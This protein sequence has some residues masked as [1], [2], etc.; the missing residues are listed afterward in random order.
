LSSGDRQI[1]FLAIVKHDFVNRQTR[2]WGSPNT[3]L[4]IANL[5]FGDRQT[6]FRRLSNAQLATAKHLSV[7]QI[8]RFAN[9]NYRIG[10]DLLLYRAITECVESR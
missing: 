8:I 4:A 7:K 3:T 1:E 2:F 9:N 10:A 5:S 6:R